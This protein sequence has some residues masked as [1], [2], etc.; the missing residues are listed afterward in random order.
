M[1]TT[2]DQN[3]N[4][5]NKVDVLYTNWLEMKGSKPAFSKGTKWC[6]TLM[7][8]DQ[9]TKLFTYIEKRFDAVDEKFADV[10]K[11]Q[12]DIKE[13]IGELS[14]QV[15]YY[16]NEMSMG[17][18]QFDKLE[19]A[20]LQIAQETGVQLKVEFKYRKVY[21]HDSCEIMRRIESV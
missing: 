12:I 19:E 3:K 18:H 17:F 7:S 8:E 6:N 21:S 2:S 5:N 1:R 20:I 4:I 10:R 9:L 14:A 13:A 16:H 11:D 15:R